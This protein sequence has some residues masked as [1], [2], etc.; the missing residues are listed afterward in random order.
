MDKKLNVI[1]TEG[2]LSLTKFLEQQNIFITDQ[3]TAKSDVFSTLS[4]H[5]DIR[6]WWINLRLNYPLPANWDDQTYYK[7]V[8]FELE[9]IYANQP[10]LS[11]FLNKT[12]QSITEKYKL[13]RTISEFEQV[14]KELEVLR[15]EKQQKQ[16][17][18]NSPKIVQ[19]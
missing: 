4:E 6:S 5:F 14:L 12:A 3:I 10:E 18:D 2:Q 11:A 16:E 8:L 7:A 19:T 15:N 9:K 13:P 17:E 1:D